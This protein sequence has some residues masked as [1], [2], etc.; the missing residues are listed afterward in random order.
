MWMPPGKALVAFK[1]LM[2][3]PEVADWRTDFKIRLALYHSATGMMRLVGIR[4]TRRPRSSVAFMIWIERSSR[5]AS[6]RSA[7]GLRALE[8]VPPVTLTW[9]VSTRGRASHVEK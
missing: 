8:K 2:A 3:F 1:T 7:A 6:E 5:A 4:E 9:A